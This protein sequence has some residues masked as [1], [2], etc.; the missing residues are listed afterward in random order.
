MTI[1]SKVQE[2]SADLVGLADELG[3]IPPSDSKGAVIKAYE[4]AK[5]ALSNLA[6]SIEKFYQDRELSNQLRVDTLAKI[7]ESPVY[8]G[9][10]I[11][12]KTAICDRILESSSKE[13]LSPQEFSEYVLERLRELSD[14]ELAKIAYNKQDIMSLGQ[15]VTK[16]VQPD[17][18]YYETG[19]EV[20]MNFVA[21]PTGREEALAR[22][23]KRVLATPDLKRKFLKLYYAT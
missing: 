23:Q 12:E 15:S 1:L 5:S 13:V 11:E 8:A 7:E 22:G 9:L 10:S 17:L 18:V 4:S 3:S 2:L 20:I 14:E 16:G 19:L 21:T 6:Y